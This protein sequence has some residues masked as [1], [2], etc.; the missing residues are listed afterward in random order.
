[1]SRAH[2][3]RRRFSGPVRLVGRACPSRGC[4]AGMAV[5]LV[6]LAPTPHG[7]LGV[8]QAFAG[9]CQAT[10]CNIVFISDKINTRVVSNII[11]QEVSTPETVKD[12]F[13]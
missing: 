12:T 8:R 9:C 11:E 13:G 10:G 1:M 4:Q 3:R 2:P 7:A 5:Q 6:D